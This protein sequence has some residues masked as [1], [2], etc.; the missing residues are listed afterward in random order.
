MLDFAE[1]LGL[2]GPGGV[3]VFLRR[4]HPAQPQH[5]SEQVERPEETFEVLVEAHETQHLLDSYDLPVG[6]LSQHFHRASYPLHEFRVLQAHAINPAGAVGVVGPSALCIET[7]EG[8]NEGVLAPDH[9]GLSVQY[10]TP[11][12]KSQPNLWA[13]LIDSVG[14]T[15]RT[16]SPDGKAK[17]LIDLRF[18]LPSR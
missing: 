6:L 7:I 11:E 8:E 13:S 3:R 9:P 15:T 14:L 4:R 16:L 12:S 1:K 18:S 10:T 2:E 17:S 5:V